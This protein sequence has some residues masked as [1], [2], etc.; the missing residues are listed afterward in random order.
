MTTRQDYITAIGHLVGGELPLGEAE[1]IFSAAL[2]K[3]SGHRPRIV[4]EDGGTF[5]RRLEKR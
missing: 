5:I 3:F 4:P 1:K 2:K